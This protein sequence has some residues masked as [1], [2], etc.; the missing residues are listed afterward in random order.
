MSSRQRECSQAA[1]HGFLSYFLVS[2]ESVRNAQA[3]FGRLQQ[4]T[5]EQRCDMKF[6][7]FYF[8]FPE[9]HSAL[10]PLSN[11]QIIYFIEVGHG[12]LRFLRKVQC[13]YYPKIFSK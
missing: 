8:I 13:S 12:L 7:L 6:G 11:N 2:L 1:V 9:E 5:A 4:N 10:F 3:A